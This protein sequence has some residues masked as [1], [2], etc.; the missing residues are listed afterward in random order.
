MDISLSPVTYSYQKLLVSLAN[1][2]MLGVTKMG[3]HP[4]SRSVTLILVIRGV[5]TK[6][7]VAENFCFIFRFLDS[8][9]R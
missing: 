1:G 6:I 5:L 8:C 7:G 3:G 9:N 2:C 4:V